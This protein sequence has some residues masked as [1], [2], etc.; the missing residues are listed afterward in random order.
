MYKNRYQNVHL[1]VR[2]S[3]NGLKILEANINEIFHKIKKKIF[4]TEIDE[5]AELQ[6]LL[7]KC[8]YLQQVLLF[9]LR[10]IS[11]NFIHWIRQKSELSTKVK[12]WKKKETE[13]KFIGK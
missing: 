4:L 3:F 10:K 6:I 5:S 13:K 2:W 8:H 9:L 12:L 7:A 1:T 11:R